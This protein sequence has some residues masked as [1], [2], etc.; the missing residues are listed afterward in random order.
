MRTC[1]DIAER[2]ASRA[3]MGSASVAEDAF[4]CPDPKELR[5]SAMP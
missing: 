2:T 4:P 3:V 1:L 5:N